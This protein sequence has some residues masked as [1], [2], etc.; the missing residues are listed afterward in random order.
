MKPNNNMHEQSMQTHV[1]TTRHTDG[2]GFFRSIVYAIVTGLLMFSFEGNYAIAA[3]REA[4]VYKNPQCGCCKEYIG[5][6][7]Q[8]GFVVK[9]V[10]TP[11]LSQIK[12]QNSVPP[13]FEGCHTTLIDGYVIEGHVPV[14]SIERLLSERPKI[15]GIALP[16]MPAGS[17]GMTGLK[18]E[19]FVIYEIA[20]GTP[21]VYSKE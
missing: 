8:N 12:R 17:P 4:T 10:D 14:K 9:A 1:A 7:R 16:G 11:D 19:P 6:L 21:R 5:Y 20:D 15:K 2:I 13:Q 18:T 3:E